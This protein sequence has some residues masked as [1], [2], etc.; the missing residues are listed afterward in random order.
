V[1]EAATPDSEW[2]RVTYK[3]DRIYRNDLSCPTTIEVANRIPVGRPPSQADAPLKGTRLLLF[4]RAA[5]TGNFRYLTHAT[6]PVVMRE[7]S[8]VYAVLPDPLSPPTAVGTGL[9]LVAEIPDSGGGFFLTAS[10]DTEVPVRL[11][12]VNNGA[13]PVDLV[14]LGA[15]QWRITLLDITGQWT[16][17]ENIAPDTL[18]ASLA[19]GQRATVEL[20]TRPQG[21]A[22]L[23][24][25][26]FRIVA[27]LVT[28]GEPVHSDA[29]GDTTIVIRDCNEF[30]CR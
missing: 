7:N 16:A 28:A 26:V 8:V 14:T 10:P 9:A 21:A 19:P 17:A 15:S 20:V 22:P 2:V 12:L 24:K 5:S 11:T 27:E 29:G 6:A 30:S 25:G 13:D 1:P 23:T 3:L 18:P 4:A